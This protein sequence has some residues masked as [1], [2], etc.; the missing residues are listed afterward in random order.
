[1]KIWGKQSAKHFEACVCITLSNRIIFACS[2]STRGG[3]MK[4]WEVGPFDSCVGIMVPD[5]A[6]AGN[7]KGNYSN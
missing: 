2:A 1:M 3:V 5:I 6:C 7:G 4:S